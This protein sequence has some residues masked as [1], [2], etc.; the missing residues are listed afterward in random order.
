MEDKET[1]GKQFEILKD[2]FSDE[3]IGEFKQ[4][5]LDMAESMKY[6]KEGFSLDMLKGGLDKIRDTKLLN[7][8]LDKLIPKN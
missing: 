1:F 6:P 2:H 5:A 3:E 8:T 7:G 4:L